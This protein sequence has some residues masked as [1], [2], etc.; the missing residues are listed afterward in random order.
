MKKTQESNEW[1]TLQGLCKDCA[2]AF[3]FEN[4]LL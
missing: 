2:N 3:K 4:E 1:S